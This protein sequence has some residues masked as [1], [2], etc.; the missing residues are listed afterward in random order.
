MGDDCCVVQAHLDAL[1][2]QR[3]EAAASMV[4]KGGLHRPAADAYRPQGATYRWG[5]PWQDADYLPIRGR[6]SAS[7]DSLA[8]GGQHM[9]SPQALLVAAQIRASK[10]TSR[11]QKHPAASKPPSHRHSKKG[12]PAPTPV[13]SVQPSNMNGV[14][15]TAG[16]HM[17]QDQD[18]KQETFRRFAQHLADERFRVGP[19]PNPN[20]K[21]PHAEAEDPIPLQP[22]SISETPPVPG[23]TNVTNVTNVARDTARRHGSGSSS[24]VVH[25][26]YSNFYSISSISTHIS[27][28]MR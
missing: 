25:T 14:P 16:G 12:I 4:T 17:P 23:V 24:P 15:Y 21:A 5:P 7:M 3:R 9:P 22:R 6:T 11:K 26:Q 27:V 28:Y 20:P 19:N 2:Q 13:S 1:H 18:A 8:V 10:G